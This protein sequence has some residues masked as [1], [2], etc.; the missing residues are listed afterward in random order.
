MLLTLLVTG[1]TLCQN[2]W[3]TNASALAKLGTDRKAFEKAVVEVERYDMEE[4]I[5]AMPLDQ[6]LDGYYPFGVS[7]RRFLA[8]LSNGHH[9]LLY[10][11]MRDGRAHTLWRLSL[12]GSER[13]KPRAVPPSIKGTMARMLFRQ[14]FLLPKK[15]TTQEESA[16][17]AVKQYAAYGY[18]GEGG[19]DL[20]AWIVQ[21]EGSWSSIYDYSRVMTYRDKFFPVLGAEASALTLGSSAWPPN[22]SPRLS[23]TVGLDN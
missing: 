16:V 4:H 18:G 6:H 2:G 15:L 9:S 20:W 22:L 7:S 14:G 21:S 3:L 13:L 23:H 1:V 10:Q 17:F 11:V 5:Y 8:S 12:G 19:E